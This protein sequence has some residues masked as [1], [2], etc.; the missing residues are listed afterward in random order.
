M[1]NRDTLLA[2]LCTPLLHIRKRRLT[3]I[4]A[5]F[6][7]EELCN[8]LHGRVSR[9]H[10]AE[11]DDADFESK[12]DTVAN[13][14][15][16]LERIK[17]N[18]VDKL[19]E[20]QGSGDAKVEPCEALGAETVRQDLGGVTSHDTGFDVVEDSI[21]ELVEKVSNMFRL[22]RFFFSSSCELTYNADDE[23]FA[24]RSP[25]RRI[26]SRGNDGE[27]VEHDKGSDGGNEID[28]TATELVDQECEEEIL[29]QCQCLHA[30]VDAELRMGIRQTNV[31]HD[32]FQVIR[33]QAVAAP[34]AEETNGSDDGNSLTV[35]LG[36]EEVGPARAVLLFVEINGRTNLCVFEL[37]KLVV[38]VSFT[39]PFGEDGKGLF[40]AVF[41]AQPAR[42][43]RHEGDEAEND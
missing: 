17:R 23:A 35:T 31:V 13:I 27:D 33:D 4:D 32:V 30:T 43:F 1:C 9:L 37:N 2:N 18:A 15:P 40:M 19:V 22:S 34:L 26:V 3:H 25:W 20:E 39:V 21:E 14:V 36:L 28:W 38:L 6:A 10:N 11:V 5:I 29:A 8:F 7:I 24:K 16:P 42:R 41:V 12:E